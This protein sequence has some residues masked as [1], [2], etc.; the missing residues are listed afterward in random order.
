MKRP[1]LSFGP[2]PQVQAQLHQIIK[3]VTDAEN[4]FNLL[5]DDENA[6]SKFAAAKWPKFRPC[7]TGQFKAFIDQLPEPKFRAEQAEAEMTKAF[8][9][10]A[11]KDFFVCSLNMH[12]AWSRARLAAAWISRAPQ[13]NAALAAAKPKAAQPQKSP[14]A[15]GPA[16]PATATKSP[17][18]PSG[19]RRVLSRAEFNCL[20]PSARLEFCKAGGVIND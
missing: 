5:R 17:N 10:D 11:W 12:P 16:R 1:F 20:T 15:A 14:V 19:G 7:L 4:A 2:K 3:G 18:T 8:G 9:G 13:I 6:A